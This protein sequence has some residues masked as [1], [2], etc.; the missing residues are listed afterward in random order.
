M[1]L[2]KFNPRALVFIWMHNSEC[3]VES[4]FQLRDRREK[5]YT[6]HVVNGIMRSDVSTQIHF[7]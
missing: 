6:E 5:I 2:S 3:L 1:R 4:Y 7:M